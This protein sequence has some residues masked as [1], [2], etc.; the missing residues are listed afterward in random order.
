MHREKQPP[1]NSHQPTELVKKGMNEGPTVARNSIWCTAKPYVLKSCNKCA[2]EKPHTSLSTRE[3][4]IPC[5]IGFKGNTTEGLQDAQNPRDDHPLKTHRHPASRRSHLPSL[6]P[7][8]IFW[9]AISKTGQGRTAPEKPRQRTTATT[10]KDQS[11][12]AQRHGSK[13]AVGQTN[14]RGEKETTTNTEKEGQHMR[15]SCKTCLR[16][17]EEVVP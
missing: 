11:T 16:A 10:D 4:V 12:W 5:T 9:V 3:V 15:D 6:H 2:A 7:V 13:G 8:R 1:H 17:A 14:D